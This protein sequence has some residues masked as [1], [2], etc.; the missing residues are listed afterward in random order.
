MPSTRTLARLLPTLA[1]LAVLGVF[2]VYPVALLLLGSVL[3]EVP[4]P[5]A[6]GNYF[7]LAHYA[8]V[9][10]DTG[11]QPLLNSLFLGVVGT[12]SAM[13]I[14]CT[15]AWLAARTDVPGKKLTPLIGV[16]PLFLPSVVG[17]LAWT[18]IASPNAGF[19]NMA[20]AA[21]G[22]DWRFNIHSMGG[23]VF[24]LALYYAPYSFMF[25]YG[26]LKLVGPELEEAAEV[27]G[28]NRWIVLTRIS[29]PSVL[30]ALIGSALLTFIM[31]VDNFPVPMV[32][33]TPVG[34]RTLPSAIYEFVAKSP[35]E[36]NRAAALGVVLTL[37]AFVLVYLQRRVT[38]GRSFETVTGKG[39][40]D[41]TPVRL[42]A[43]RW[44][45]AAFMWLYAL[46]A[47][48][49]PVFAILQTS[50]RSKQYVSRFSD[51]AGID[52]LSLKNW[53]ELLSY[54]PFTVGFHNSL[55]TGVL[56]GVIGTL[57]C[58][59]LSLIVYRSQL[60]GRRWVE[61]IAMLPVAVPAL[62][63]GLG[64]FWAWLSL[65][66]PLFGTLAILVLAYIIVFMPQ[67]FRSV[68]ASILQVGKDLEDAAS[69]SGASRL[70]TLWHVTI[71]LIR[72]SLVSTTVLLFILSMRELTVSVFLYT[73][74]TRVLSVVLFEQWSSGRHPRV[75]S[76]S[77]VYC[78][79][80]LVVLLVS[81]RWLRVAGSTQ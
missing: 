75:A 64:I 1:V 45:A 18:W 71:P 5:G 74:H 27:H 36:P 57:V 4:R 44:P 58:L 17:A 65:P 7:T 13:F 53:N 39:L 28:A 40:S 9:Y 11:A 14:G 61:Y 49:A 79:T 43:W 73:A 23:I 26:A 66:I 69:I 41:R 15:L 46:I 35:S 50:L 29:I 19:L 8:Y 63:L 42:G 6:T 22:S 76:I 32:L 72:T 34:I 24:V 70:Q 21:A 16:M 77:L 54:E 59:V 81:R 2:V 30:P 47:V 33:G 3:G 67:G 80:L 51:L 52:S 20:L 10:S 60:I 56:S 37:V 38:G 78:V 62:V 48:G 68:S 31:V 12:L 55:V 25:L